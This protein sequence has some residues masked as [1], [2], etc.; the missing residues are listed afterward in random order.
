MTKRS[1]R[2]LVESGEYVLG[3]GASG[4]RLE[5]ETPFGLDPV[6]HVAGTLR[7]PRLLSAF[8]AINLG[9]LS[10]AAALGLP[11]VMMT[12]TFRAS[13]ERLREAGIDPESENL[14]RRG[15]EVCRAI[16]ARFP[17]VDIYLEGTIGP[18]GDNQDPGDTL[19]AEA[20]E[21]RHAIQACEL[22][23]AG[24]DVLLGATVPAVE[25]A[26]GMARAL[27]STGTPYAISLTIGAGGRVADGSTLANA[28]DRIDGAVSP[29]PLHYALV[30]V[31]PAVARLALASGNSSRRVRELRGNG[32][33]RAAG[34]LEG[35]GRVLADHPET[36]AEAM[37]SVA[38]ERGLNVLGGCC[39]TD[40]RHILSLGLRMVQRP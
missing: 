20:A 26:T 29:P 31:H 32:A 39:G 10:V 9:Y 16:S 15:V 25:E 4:T 23:E 24:V 34:E 21:R 18:S 5:F 33:P 19:D 14:N 30:C 3:D 1:F 11:F 8:N 38:L 17:D 37:M 28:I 7:D 22:A 36:W 40:E 27:G 6:L 12:P 13:R 2:D 35:S